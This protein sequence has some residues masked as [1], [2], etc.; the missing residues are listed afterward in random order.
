MT[1]INADF[2]LICAWC[3]TVMRSPERMCH[4]E[5]PESHGVCSCCATAMGMPAHLLHY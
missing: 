2:R 1:Y 4:D 5:V 3:N